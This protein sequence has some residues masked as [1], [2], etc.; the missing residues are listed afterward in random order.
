MSYH[1]FYNKQ[2]VKLPNGNILPM[3]N[4]GDNNCTEE[5]RSGRWRRSR[6]WHCVTYYNGEQESRR[7]L[8]AAPETILANVQAE[9]DEYVKKCETD[10]WYKKQGRQPE[11]V[12]NTHYQSQL[13]NISMQFSQMARRV[14][15]SMPFIATNGK[16]LIGMTIYE[17][18]QYTEAYWT[19]RAD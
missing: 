6:N 10:E 7:P 16:E 14:K 11:D 8:S 17:A 19:S 15:L 9:I 13:T 2:F 1:I 18:R 5:T 4:S 3:V 12:S